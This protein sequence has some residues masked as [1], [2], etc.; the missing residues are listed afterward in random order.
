MSTKRRDDL[1]FLLSVIRVILSHF[2]FPPCDRRNYTCCLTLR[3]RQLNRSLRYTLDLFGRR[4]HRVGSDDSVPASPPTIHLGI[5]KRF[6]I[7]YLYVC[8]FYSSMESR[9]YGARDDTPCI[10][11][12]VLYEP[13][14]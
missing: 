2:Y 12:F 14:S 7:I 1:A 10:V 9:F 13:Y 4:I 5:L 8:C 11:E 6:F 3:D